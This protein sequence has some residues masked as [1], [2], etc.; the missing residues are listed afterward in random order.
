MKKLCLIIP[1]RGRPTKIL[2]TLNSIDKTC[3]HLNTDVFILLDEDDTSVVD[4]F[5]TVPNWVRIKV[6][7]RD[8][9]R[10]L[11]TEIINRCF[12]EHNNYEFYSVTNDDIIYLTEGWDEALCQKMKI[13]CGQDDTMVEKYGNHYIGNIKPG[14]FPI[15]S[16]ID[17][18]ICRELGWL[19]YPELIHS[20][21]DNIWFW[22]GKRANCLY[23]DGK[24]HTVH[25]SPYFDKCEADETFNKCNAQDNQEDYYIYKEWLK[26]KCGKEVCKIQR[27]LKREEENVKC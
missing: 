6:Y 10:T 27:L 17:G 13:S 3:N 9:D 11:T 25:M 1:S 21:G 12:D 26:Y 24:Y 7:N 22:I 23:H 20:C 2:D 8:K 18:D 15:T 5:K 16:V 19:Q 14:E 4:Y